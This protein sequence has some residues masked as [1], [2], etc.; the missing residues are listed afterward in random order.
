MAIH[1]IIQSIINEE[2]SKVLSEDNKKKPQVSYKEFD[3][4]SSSDLKKYFKFFHLSNA[5]KNKLT[6]TPRVPP[7]PW[8]DSN[9]DIT[10]DDFTPRVSL[11]SSLDDADNALEGAGAGRYVFAGEIKGYTGDNVTAIHLKKKIP[12]CPK[13]KD[14]SYDG[15]F[16]MRNWLDEVNPELSDSSGR[17][18]RPATLPPKEKNKFAGCVPDAR[19]TNEYWSLEPVPLLGLG[20]YI[21]PDSA[22]S[23][24][25]F[26]AAVMNQITD[27]AEEIDYE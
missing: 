5:K 9:G 12:K 19:E 22:V 21:V 2:I 26:G 16:L 1:P 25:K 17:H 15:D 8:N 23:L 10:E 7:N 13:T 3:V 27:G 11:A 24:S 6:L 20:D 4:I 18:L 14:M